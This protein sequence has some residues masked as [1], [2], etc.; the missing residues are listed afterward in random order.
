MADSQTTRLKLILALE[1]LTQSQDASRDT[2]V[3][4]VSNLVSLTEKS[5][6][7]R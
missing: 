7:L 6:E 4:W 3:S 5:D 1:E 2:I